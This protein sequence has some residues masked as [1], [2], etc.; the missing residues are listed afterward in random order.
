[1]IYI[2]YTSV[3]KA[4]KLTTWTMAVSA[5]SRA[6]LTTDRTELTTDW[7][8]LTTDGTELTTGRT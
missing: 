4:D 7:T 6:E 5:M 2:I 1:M 8:E 3:V